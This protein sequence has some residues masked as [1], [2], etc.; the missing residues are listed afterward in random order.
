MA[1]FRIFILFFIF[2]LRQTTV[3]ECL[4]STKFSFF[5]SPKQCFQS[6]YCYKS[7]VYRVQ[8]KYY[9]TKTAYRTAYPAIE[10]S[11]KDFTI[12]GDLI[13]PIE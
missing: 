9:S 3:I 5:Q 12:S 1:Y 10:R 7:D 4:S 8:S 11:S 2:L 6:D 13:C